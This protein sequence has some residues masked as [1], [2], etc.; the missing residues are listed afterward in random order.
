VI[1][2]PAAVLFVLSVAV[3]ALALVPAVGL[4]A[5]GG[6]GAQGGGG[7]PGGGGGG[8]TSTLTGPVMVVDSNANHAAN[9]NDQVTFNVST[10]ATDRPYVLLNCYQSGRWVSTSSVGF[11]PEYPWAPTFTLA[12]GAWTS[13]AADCIA[14]LYMVTSNGKQQ[15]LASMSLHVDA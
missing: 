15:N 2:K 13:G 9:W 4:A 14:T 1:R 12:S 10:N 8:S 3:L 7:K 11:F 6:N 5:K